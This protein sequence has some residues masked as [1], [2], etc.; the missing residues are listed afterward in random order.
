MMD[1]AKCTEQLT[2]FLDGELS[3]VDSERI[4]SHLRACTFCLDELRSLEE[5][6]RFVRRHLR[7]LEVNPAAWHLVRARISAKQ[8]SFS[9]ARFANLYRRPLTV[10]AVAVIAIIAFAIFQHHQIQRRSLEDYMNR[11]V[12]YRRI[13]LPVAPVFVDSEIGQEN[14]RTYNPFAEPEYHPTDNPFRLEEP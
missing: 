3:P 6:A 13:N 14:H 5:S 7:E 11:Y 4:K 1:C 10:A 12:A 2:A 8:Q 9:V